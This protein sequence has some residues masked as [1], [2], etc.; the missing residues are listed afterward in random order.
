MMKQ[1]I[2]FLFVTLL[3]ILGCN[4]E[5]ELTSPVENNTIQEP[6]WISLPQAEGLYINTEYTDTRSWDGKKS[7]TPL[8]INAS[9][10]GGPFGLVT[11][12]ASLSTERNS[13]TGIRT[14]S[15]TLET[16]STVVTFGP[17]QVFII[18]LKYNVTFT[19]VDLS[20]INPA[21]VQFAYIAADGSIQYAE[22]DGII[23]NLATG[24][25]GVINARIP[26]FSRYGFVN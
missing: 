8:S 13:Y 1:L 26:H 24:K 17:E 7:G 5:S 21:T 2:S 23:V 12:N 22:N 25:L 15:M 20:G 18:P 6:N 19:G 10:Y 11:I 9:Y 3:L 14:L 4:N 16:N